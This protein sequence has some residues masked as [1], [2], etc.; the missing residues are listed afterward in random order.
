MPKKNIK[1]QFLS[2]LSLVCR[3]PIPFSFTF[4][5]KRLDLWL[6][7]TSLFQSLLFGLSL[8]LFILLFRSLELSVLSAL[9]VYYGVFNL[10]HFDGLLDTA[11]AFL[12]AFEREKRQ[13]ILKDPRLGV[14]AVFTGIIYITAK[15]LVLLSLLNLCSPCSFYSPYS[16]YSSYSPRA[17]L[18]FQSLKALSFRNVMGLYMLFL[19]PLA[20][21]TGAA[22]IPGLFLPAKAEGLGALAKGSKVGF[23]LFGS[24]LSF[25]FYNLVFLGAFLGLPFSQPMSG[26]MLL[27]MVLDMLMA[28]AI[29]I[30][31][32]VI[33]G[34]YIGRL[35]QKGLGGYTGDSLGAAIELGELLY[36]LIL[37]V[38][39]Q[40]GMIF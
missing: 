29:M 24:G 17:A 34:L 11:D 5:V 6:P 2:T 30:C 18:P 13:E 15:I 19:F 39:M 28:L 37:Y 1:D 31:S 33:V 9:A 21:K 40:R 35:Y 12:G 27:P 10:F 14:Y 7:L 22:L 32:A 4:N 20:G 3:I 8:A 16:P 25:L 26:D 36:L 23:S 38:L